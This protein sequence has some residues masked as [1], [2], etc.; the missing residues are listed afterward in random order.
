[1]EQAET[2]PESKLEKR[3]TVLTKEIKATQSKCDILYER[4]KPF[5]VNEGVPVEAKKV[6]SLQ[7]PKDSFVNNAIEEARMAIST[8]NVCLQSM[9]ESID[10]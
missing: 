6:G 5:I 4:I 2:K 10:L 7:E 9:I 3:L 1:M 8:V